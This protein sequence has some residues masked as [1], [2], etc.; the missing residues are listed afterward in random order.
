MKG[1]RKS[2]KETKILNKWMKIAKAGGYV[3]N[4]TKN[5][6]LLARTSAVFNGACPCLPSQRP[7]CPCKEMKEEIEKQ[8]HCFCGVFCTKEY[9]KRR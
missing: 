5:L 1:Y 7:N 8:G 4:T 6:W 3:L 9:F 2:N